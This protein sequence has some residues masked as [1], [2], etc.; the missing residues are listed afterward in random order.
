MKTVGTVDLI[1]FG[2]VMA[3]A[4]AIA[5]M[6][7]LGILPWAGA[8]NNNDN[9]LAA[10]RQAGLGPTHGQTEHDWEVGMLR[11][12]YFICDT[13]A[14]GTMTREAIKASMAPDT[15]LAK[16]TAIVDGAISNLCPQYW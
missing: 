6:V 11:Q 4:C 15:G 14:R 16:T 8:D 3:C 12:G 1:P 2:A 7:L 13:A 10:L 5:G 9:Y